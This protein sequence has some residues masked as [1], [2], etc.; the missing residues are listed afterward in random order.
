[1]IV[2]INMVI[3]VMVSAKIAILGPLK[4]KIFWKKGYDVIVFVQDVTYK[5]H[6][7]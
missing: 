1:M 4:I 5:I 3:I 2:L 6:L 7:I